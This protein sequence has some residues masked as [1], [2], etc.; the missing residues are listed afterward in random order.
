LD[1]KR[2]AERDRDREDQLE[3]AVLSGTA[4]RLHPA[5]SIKSA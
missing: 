5:Q 2:Q 1:R 3:Q 4:K